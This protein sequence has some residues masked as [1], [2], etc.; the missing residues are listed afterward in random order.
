VFKEQ[1]QIILTDWQLARGVASIKLFISKNN[2]QIN[3]QGVVTGETVCN[4]K[5]STIAEYKGIWYQ[6]RQ[7]AILR[8]DYQSAAVLYRELCPR[9]PLPVQPELLAEYIKCKTQEKNSSH[10]ACIRVQIKYTIAL[11][12]LNL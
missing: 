8:V 9:N 12:T 6:L 4:A 11:V 7:F 10:Y 1:S 3:K 5:P 2:L